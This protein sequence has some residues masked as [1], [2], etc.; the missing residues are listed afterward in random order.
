MNYIEKYFICIIWISVEIS[1]FVIFNDIKKCI[2][3][4]KYISNIEYKLIITYGFWRWWNADYSKI[5]SFLHHIF[6]LCNIL[7][8]IHY[9]TNLMRLRCI[10]SS[11]RLLVNFT[12]PHIYIINLTLFQIFDIHVWWLQVE[13]ICYQT[14]P[15]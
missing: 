1:N 15:K 2:L 12:L 7:H 5:V 8:N 4:L 13:Y 3:I 6:H 10:T 14:V 11:M 9:W